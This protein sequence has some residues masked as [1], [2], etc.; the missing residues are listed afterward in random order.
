MPLVTTRSIPGRVELTAML[1]MIMATG[2]LGIDLM[3]PAFGDIRSD[4]GLA[5]D[6]TAVAGIVTAYFIGMAVGQPV[7]GAIA[8]RYGRKR[9]LVAGLLLYG[10]SATV[11]ALSVSLGMLLIAAFQ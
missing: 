1:A 2:A 9:A 7:F 10:V 6:S 3:L 8:D 11:A 5:S 4:F